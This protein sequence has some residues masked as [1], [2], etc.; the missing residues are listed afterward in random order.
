MPAP[1]EE[2]TGSPKIEGTLNSFQAV[3]RF[4][5]NWSDS[6]EFYNDLMGHWT[7]TG[8]GLAYILPASFPGIPYALCHKVSIDPYPEDFIP[9]TG[10]SSDLYTNTNQ[11]PYGIVTAV[12]I[13]PPQGDGSSSHTGMPTAPAGTYLSLHVDV[14]NTAQIVSKGLYYAPPGGQKTLIEDAS[15]PIVQPMDSFTMSWQKIPISLI[16][17][18]KI[19]KARGR[20]NASKFMNYDPDVVLFAGAQMQYEFQ[21]EGDIICSLDYKFIAKTITTLGSEDTKSGWTYFFISDNAGGGEY[22]ELK[23]KDDKRF[24]VQYDFDS[25]FTFA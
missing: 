6:V 22:R 3:R 8:S 17:W 7:N 19:N 11:P 14:G 18:E 15:Y 13:I 10:S 20:V 9:V 25:L 4:K 23:T 1:F 2:L 24:Y 12:Y 16:P 5:I 21:F